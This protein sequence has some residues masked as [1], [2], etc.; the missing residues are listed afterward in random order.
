MIIS[1]LELKNWRNFR[2]VDVRFGS[3]AFLVGPNAAGKSNLLDAI[4]F[5]RDIAKPGGGLQTALDER[6]GLSKI[7]CL[8]ARQHPDVEL[9]LELSDPAQGK[10][11]PEWRYEIGIRQE[12]RNAPAL[13][14]ERVWRDGNRLLDRPL[15]EDK[16]DPVRLTQTHL[17]Q[18]NANVGFRAVAEFL[19]SVLYLHVVPQLIR[20]PRAFSGEGIPGD[21]FGLHLLKRIGSTSP[22]SRD[23]RLRRIASALQLAVPNLQELTYKVDSTEG[24]IPH[25]EATYKHWRPNGAKQRETE[26]SDGTLRLIGLLWA[27]LEDDTPLL[28][29]EPELSL[30]VAIVRQLPALMHRLTR[31][32]KRQVLVSTHSADLLSDKSISGEE[33]LLLN[34][35]PEGTTV[36]AAVEIEGV[37]SL[38]ESGL[39]VGE[40]II[41]RTEPQ[42]A[43]QLLLAFM[44]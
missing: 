19:R 33:V 12:Q 10:K 41:P 16:L 32:L 27:L 15:P 28:L 42:D 29:E 6:G 44:K 37:R 36:Q 4:R 14:Y 7:R 24:G 23:S 43:R 8:A 40:A 25:L 30:N 17:E 20:F 34:P 26:F 3:R 35:G 31:K 18:I 5:L 2:E 22:K 21:P 38:L 39:S 1:R 9:T 13:T 11:S